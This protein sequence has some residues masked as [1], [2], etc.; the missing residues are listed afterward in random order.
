MTF[1][2]SSFRG[3]TNGSRE[4]APDDKLRREPGISRRNLEIPGSTLV[5]RP[6]M[7]ERRSCISNNC[8]KLSFEGKE[9]S[10]LAV[11]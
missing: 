5:R 11:G 6:G 10:S 8:M 9:M 7:T 1:G 3:A 4:C 2:L